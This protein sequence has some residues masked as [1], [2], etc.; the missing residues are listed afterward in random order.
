MGTNRIELDD[1]AYDLLKA[2]RRDDESFSDA[3]KR[4]IA[5]VTSDWR[6]S[7]GT[8][9]GDIDEFVNAAQRSREATSYGLA[10]R[11]EEANKLFEELSDINESREDDTES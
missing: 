6:H 4:I 9:E 2:E 7:I 1:E 3:V 5:E 10:R 11:Q 8:Y